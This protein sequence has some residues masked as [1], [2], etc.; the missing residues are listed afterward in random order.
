MVNLYLGNNSDTC[1]ERV[2]EDL[3][4]K[5]ASRDIIIIAPDAYS[6]SVENQ[7]AQI[8]G[9]GLRAE[10]MSFARFAMRVLGNNVKKCLTPIGCTMIMTKALSKISD[11]LNY[12]GKAL[13]R[14]SFVN[15]IYGSIAALRNSGVTVESLRVAASTMKGYNKNK[16]EDL[17]VI[18]NAYMEELRTNYNDPTTRLQEL[19]AAIPS[20]SYVRESI[21]CIVD[22]YAFNQM[23]YD[24]IEKLMTYAYEVNVALV[25]E[26]GGLGNQAIF[27]DVTAEAIKTLA[28]SSGVPVKRIN[29]YVALDSFSDVLLNRLYDL[30]PSPSTKTD[31]QLKLLRP[32][33]PQDEI[34]EVMRE[35]AKLVRGGMR[36][37][38]IA[39]VAG[40]VDDPTIDGAFEDHGIP[41]FKNKQVSLSEEP[42]V[43]YVLNMLKLAEDIE[44]DAA[45]SFIRNPLSGIDALDSMK[46]ENFTIKFG[47]D[48]T[49]RFKKS[50]DFAEKDYE[51]EENV[52]LA[53]LAQIPSLPASEVVDVY[54]DLIK[55]HLINID[56]DFRLKAFFE[57][58]KNE[59]AAARTAQVPAKL[60][61]ALDLM[62]ELL[63]GFKVELSEFYDILRASLES[64][65]VALIPS[66]ADCVYVG[67]ARD[68]KYENVKA[69]FVIG[70][71]NGKIPMETSEGSILT[72]KYHTELQL[73]DLVV[74]PA[75]KEENKFARFCLAEILCKPKELLVVSCPLCS[76]TG[77]TICPSEIFD[78]LGGLFDVQVKSDFEH[79]FAEKT[80]TEKQSLKLVSY[81]IRNSSD[82]TPYRSLMSALNEADQ[83]RVSRI[84][85]VRNESEISC[86]KELFL[87]NDASSVSK[88]ETYLSCPYSF[89]LKY[90]LGAKEKEEQDVKAL[91]IGIVMHAVMERF[92]K[93]HKDKYLSY[94]SEKISNIAIEIAD[95]V[96]NEDPRLRSLKEDSGNM[97]LN[98]LKAET[99]MLVVLSA[100][101]TKRGDFHPFMFEAKIGGKDA[102]IPSVVLPSGTKLVGQIDRIDKCDND[103]FV[104]DYK[105]GMVEP[106]LNEIYFGEKIQLYVYAKALMDVGYNVVGAFYQGLALK[107]GKNVERKEGVY[108]GQTIDRA[109]DRIDRNYKE[110]YSS[111]G[112]DFT[113]FSEEQFKWIV[114]YVYALAD[115]TDGDIRSGKI[116]ATSLDCK[117]CPAKN[118]C[119]EA[120]V[121][122][123]KTKEVKIESFA[124]IASKG[125]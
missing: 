95:E 92:F 43:K 76:A 73:R 53:L 88:L 84:F 116:P 121:K 8:E 37:K 36:Y 83:A 96:I 106:R 39:V 89:F 54:V 1:A 74:R 61:D 101:Y 93:E 102:D 123:R 85:E 51:R 47:I 77:A 21:V 48:H 32:S 49:A 118:V 55:E 75:V 112:N 25:D 28:K 109:I 57:K 65:K 82:A 13:K 44:R 26:V 97:R 94:S 124:P 64:V 111:R 91:E 24:V 110:W 90:G 10:V 80:V 81:G 100:E 22:F 63:C 7:I 5:D 17:A 70:A 67:E 19:C 3:K 52:R 107:Y 40:N 62:K 117:Y 86:G 33:T 78:M 72:D 34:D 66:R 50:F 120:D 15:E 16:T 119:Y 14:K 30:S 46:F 29:A 122:K 104:L 45:I 113:I 99:A 71:E 108:K 69:L 79:E 18:Y 56:F 105:T 41:Y 114:D 125:E 6:F 59:D 103:V 42:S 23:Q 115:K 20:S 27:P 35:I 11:K 87:F 98:N 2:I 12:Y 38:D 9:L 58:Q 68:C 4:T 60:S 31:V